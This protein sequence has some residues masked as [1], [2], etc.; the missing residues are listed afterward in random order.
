MMFWV[1]PVQV[2]VDLR[3]H[4]DELDGAIRFGRVAKLPKA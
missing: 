1:R 2:G 4:F 3:H